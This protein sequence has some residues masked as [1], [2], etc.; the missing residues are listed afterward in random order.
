VNTHQPRHSSV[1]VEGSVEETFKAVLPDLNALPVESLLSVNLEIAS[2]VAVAFGVLPSIAQQ[3]EAIEKNLPGFDLGRFDKLEA[4]TT[5]LS[6]AHR[7]HLIATQPPDELK[8]LY[9]EASDLRE[10]FHKDATTLVGRGYFGAEVLKDLKGANGFKNAALDLQILVGALKAN[11]E[12]IQGKCAIELKELEYADQLSLHLL[13][14][15]GLREQGPAGIARAAD[16][17]LRAYT[18]FVTAYDDARRAISFLRWHEGDVD[19]IAPS[20]FAGR[21]N[22]RKKPADDAAPQAP[23]APNDDTPA[24]VPTAPK[25]TSTASTSPAQASASGPFV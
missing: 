22:G 25:G 16:L 23:V 20:L 11:W 7:Q 17:R 9:E 18:L 24:A 21:S 13:R 19:R 4:Y 3:R 12:K 10:L 2:A 8:S 6:V 5:A 1:L 15:Y 14:V